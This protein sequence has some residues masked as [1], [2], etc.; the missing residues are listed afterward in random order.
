VPA[1]A[2]VG[3]TG[4]LTP[5]IVPLAGE[6]GTPEAVEGESVVELAGDGRVL[7]DPDAAVAE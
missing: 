1:E 5:R 3:W 4:A 6:P 7:V 2:L